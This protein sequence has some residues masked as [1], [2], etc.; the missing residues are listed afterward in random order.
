MLARGKAPR[1]PHRGGGQGLVP[2]TTTPLQLPIP[3]DPPYRTYGRRKWDERR[4]TTDSTCPQTDDTH[5]QDARK[6][7]RSGGEGVCDQTSGFPRGGWCR[8]RWILRGRPTFSVGMT[9]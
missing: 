7:C 3:P 1:A 4:T 2:I 9:V 8:F 6:A 5:P